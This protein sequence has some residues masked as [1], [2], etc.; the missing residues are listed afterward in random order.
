MTTLKDPA[1]KSAADASCRKAPRSQK[2][3]NKTCGL[4]FKGEVTDLANLTIPRLRAV[5]KDNAAACTAEASTTAHGLEKQASPAQVSCKK[6]LQGIFAAEKQKDKAKRD[7]TS[8]IEDGLCS[9]LAEAPA[10]DSGLRR[11]HDDQAEGDVEQAAATGEGQQ[12]KEISEEGCSTGANSV[13]TGAQ[14]CSNNPSSRGTGILNSSV[15][16]KRNSGSR[17][18]GGRKLPGT[19]EEDA[20]DASFEL[21]GGAGSLKVPLACHTAINKRRALA[22]SQV[23]L[24]LFFPPPFLVKELSLEIISG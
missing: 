17:R 11:I 1:P 18:I 13:G 5:V 16:P 4:L 22:Q 14:V 21:P 15:V 6:A 19:E 3:A 10:V 9:T 20:E 2:V 8:P 7:A 23:L 24:P 12:R